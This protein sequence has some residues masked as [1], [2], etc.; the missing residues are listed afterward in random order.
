MQTT[1]VIAA[2]AS[3]AR[4][5]QLLGRN[6]IEEIETFVHPEGRQKDRELRTDAMGQYFPKG[7]QGSN[8]KMGHSAVE[9]TDPTEHEAE[10]FSRTL[11]DYLD[12]ARTQRKYDR[13]CLIAPP[14]FLGLIRQNLSKDAQR[15]V[16]K[17]VPKDI[18]WF[19]PRDIEN[20]IKGINELPDR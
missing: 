17:E 7:A 16:D 12:K 15:M 3:R 10:V 11:G 19:N 18:S 4:V 9:P 1:W 13:L 8:A 20:Y 6:N 5:F 2:D 14:K